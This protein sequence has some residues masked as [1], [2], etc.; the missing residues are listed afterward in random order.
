MA[1][2]PTLTRLMTALRTLPGVGTRTAERLA[3]H[4]LRAPEAEADELAQAIL[5]LRRSVV[6]CSMCHTV[7][8][9]DPCPICADDR[10]D[11]R[12]LLVVEQPRDVQAFEDAGWKGVYHV[13][14]GH[15]NALEGIEAADLT[16]E[17]LLARVSAGGLDEVIIA[18]N[19]DYEGDTT[20]LH[21]RK[22]L[23]GAGV[24]VSRIARGIASGSAIEYSNAAMLADALSGRAPMEASA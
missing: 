14:L 16:I 18:T 21:L 10:R 23:A 2:P 11:R 19:P 17:G 6:A 3:F 7:A 15:L 12:R 24:T 5:A 13:L 8:E 9:A 1:L 22:R 20:A 4:V